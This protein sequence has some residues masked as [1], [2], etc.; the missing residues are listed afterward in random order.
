MIDVLSQQDN[1]G[2]NKFRGKW[3]NKAAGGKEP[4]RTMEW[5][6]IAEL[7]WPKWINSLPFRDANPWNFVPL[8]EL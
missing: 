3:E 2:L 7:S 5:I 8:I 6:F 4:G 1:G